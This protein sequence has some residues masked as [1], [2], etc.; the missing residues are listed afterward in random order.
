M[1]LQPQRAFDYPKWDDMKGVL[2]N[3]AFTTITM[4]L[5]K[6]KDVA[7]ALSARISSF[8]N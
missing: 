2:D 4:T 7:N 3:L 6:R 8:V 1:W 5:K